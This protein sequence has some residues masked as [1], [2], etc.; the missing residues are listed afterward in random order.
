MSIVN[1]S[2][3][4]N[5][6]GIINNTLNISSRGGLRTSHV[7]LNIKKGDELSSPLDLVTLLRMHLS[8][9]GQLLED[10]D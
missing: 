7:A 9:S 6:K 2:L 8:P 3:T 10:S 5:F 1:I 4:S